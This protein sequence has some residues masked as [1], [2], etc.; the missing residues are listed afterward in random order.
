MPH[1][2]YQPHKDPFHLLFGLLDGPHLGLP[3]HR[4]WLFNTTKLTTCLMASPKELTSPSTP[5]IADVKV[6][7]LCLTLR[8][9]KLVMVLSHHKHLARFHSKWDQY[10]A[11]VL[12]A[13]AIL[14][15]HLLPRNNGV[16]LPF[17]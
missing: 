7:L 2:G 11:N 17:T 8:K 16:T 13:S 9:I 14:I 12:P 15:S 4:Q 6:D 3:K 5:T 1:T 10:V